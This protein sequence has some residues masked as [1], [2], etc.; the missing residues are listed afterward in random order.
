MAA[1]DSTFRA[2]LQA[3]V[4]GELKNEDVVVR[5]LP[6]VLVKALASLRKPNFDPRYQP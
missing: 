5:T 4:L 1:L 2:E 6:T 3:A